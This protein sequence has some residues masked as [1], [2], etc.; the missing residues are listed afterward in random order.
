MSI[1][2][3]MQSPIARKLYE[4]KFQSSTAILTG[5]YKEARTAQKEF[6]KLA[7]KNFDIA[8]QVPAPI[9][10]KFSLFSKQGLKCLK[11]MIYKAFCKSSPEEKELKSLVNDYRDNLLD[12]HQ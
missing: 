5:N 12:M 2:K 7:V 3:I 9:K 1:Q 11:F 4:L 8:L 6:A 10:A